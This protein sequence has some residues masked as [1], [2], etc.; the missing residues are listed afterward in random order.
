MN[1]GLTIAAD[2]LI[3]EARFHIQAPHLEDVAPAMA[4][5]SAYAEAVACEGTST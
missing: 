1:T 2:V 3:Q 5:H 4:S